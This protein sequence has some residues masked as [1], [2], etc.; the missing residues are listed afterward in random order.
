[1]LDTKTN[2]DTEDKLSTKDCRTWNTDDW[3]SIDFKKEEN[4]EV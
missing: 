2:K 4:I 1:M 3:G